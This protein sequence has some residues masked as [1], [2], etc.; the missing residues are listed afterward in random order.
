MWDNHTTIAWTTVSDAASQLQEEWLL[1]DSYFMYQSYK[2]YK[3]NF[4]DCTICSIVFHLFFQ[5]IEFL[6]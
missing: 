3:T 1:L 5:K 6:M 4:K 2:C